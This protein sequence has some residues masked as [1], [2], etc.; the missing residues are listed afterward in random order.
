MKN[1]RGFSLIELLIVVVIIGIIAA[2]AIPNL[3]ASRRSANEGATISAMRTLHG[4]QMT[5]GSTYGS[6]SYSSTLADLQT[7]SLI[8][9]T[10]GSGTK[11][12][13]NYTVTANAPTTT[14]PAT[15]SFSAVPTTTSG[16]TQT[17]TRNLC[18]RTEGII[19]YESDP[20]QLGSQLAYNECADGVT[21]VFPL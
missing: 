17:G 14:A 12:G 21:N 10:L 18:I 7:V 13:Y 5:Y 3:L 15:F 9:S 4:A 6:G 1:Q 20:G 16:V 19:R 8:D 11:S 2:I